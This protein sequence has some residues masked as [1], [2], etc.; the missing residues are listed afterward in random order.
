MFDTDSGSD[1]TDRLLPV[2]AVALVSIVVGGTIDLVMDQPER[3]LSFHVIFET[4]MIAG[5]LV[6]ATTLWLGWWRAEGE[7]RSLRQTLDE[8][9][10][11]RD[12]WRQS[13]EHALEG[14]A[15]AIRDQFVAWELTPAER[16][17]A[18]ML[19]K[20]HT[21]K[22]IARLTDRS[23]QT[24]RQHAASVYAK[25]GLSSRAELSAF[26]LADLMLPEEEGTGATSRTS[27]T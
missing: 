25:A 7:A 12:A 21:H 24:V 22:H 27:G 2:L 13:A 26:F 18:L 17:V 3:W 5:A 20:G 9:S 15:H 16:D 8:R 14:L 19:L 4:L 10:A 23:A 11:E 1:G 6:M